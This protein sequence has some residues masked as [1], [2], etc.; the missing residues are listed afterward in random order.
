MR[1]EWIR[2]ERKTPGAEYYIG[3]RVIGTVV[4]RDGTTS[5]RLRA[6]GWTIKK[7]PVREGYYIV[8][9]RIYDLRGIRKDTEHGPF[10]SLA[11]A[12]AAAEVMID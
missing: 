11:A 12:K 5:P 6:N 10:S 2:Y 4:H 7:F 1:F 8:S 9:T 3:S